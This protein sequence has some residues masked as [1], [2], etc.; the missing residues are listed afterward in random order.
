MYLGSYSLNQTY[1]STYLLIRFLLDFLIAY[2]VRKMLTC[3][4]AYPSSTFI[5]QSAF[6]H[7]HLLFLTSYLCPFN[8]S[9]NLTSDLTTNLT[10]LTWP[11]WYSWFIN[12]ESIFW[13]DLR[14]DFWSTTAYLQSLARNLTLLS[15]SNLWILVTYLHSLISNLWPRI[16]DFIALTKL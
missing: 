2:K 9:S 12:S 4:C 10:S 7:K 5:I 11:F 1:Y 14:P 6:D 15:T 16:L 8:L 3:I 13:L